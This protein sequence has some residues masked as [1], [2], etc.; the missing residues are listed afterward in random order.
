MTSIS[1]IKISSGDD[2]ETQLIARLIA[3]D[4][5][6]FCSLIRLHQN[7]MLAIAR[8]ISGDTFAEDVV[9]DAWLAIH[10]NIANF[11]R[12]SSLKTWIIAI[13][14]NE[15]KGRRRR[16]SRRVSLDELDGEIPGSYLDAAHFSSDGH[17]SAPISTWH[18]ESPEQLLEEKQ[19]QQ[20]I[21][22]TLNILPATQKAAFILR[23]IERE[24]FADICIMLEIS[25][26]NVRV[27]VHR[28]RLTLMQVI[29]RFQETGR[30]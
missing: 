25:A 28:A 23:D 11:E 4:D 15:A 6:A 18:S 30:C 7:T 27:L 13:V 9:Q 22:K 5:R 8:A 20:C 14:S 24:S 17:W 29:D 21:N 10:K 26:A 3:G 16:E 1:S 2:D 12:K 19:L